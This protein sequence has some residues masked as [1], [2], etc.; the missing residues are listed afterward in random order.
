MKPHRGRPARSLILAMT[1]VGLIAMVACDAQSTGDAR[2]STVSNTDNRDR[3]TDASSG[4][5]VTKRAEPSTEKTKLVLARSKIKHVVFLIKENRT[6]DHMFGRLRRANGAV[7]GEICNG[8]TVRLRRAEDHVPDILHSFSAGIVAINGGEMNCFDRLSGGTE[9]EGYVQYHKADIPNYWSYAKQFSLADRFFSSVYGPTT[10]EHL[11]TMAGQSDR[12]VDVERVYQSGVGKQGEFCK[13]RQELM[14]SFRK[15]SQAEE[16]NAYRLEE[17]SDVSGLAERFWTERWPCTDMRVLQDLLEEQGVS[18]RYYRGGGIHQKAAIKMIRHIRLGPMWRKVVSNK[19]FDADVRRGRL[20]SVSWLLPPPGFTDHPSNPS[21]C[22]GENWTVNR[23]NLLMNSR[24]WR[25]TAVILTWDD[26]GGFYDHVPPPHVDL[27]GM[28]PR[29]PAIV[30][31]PWA[32]S[33]YVDHHTY[34]FSS[35]LKTIEEL[36]GLGS[37]GE[38]DKRADAMWQSFDFDQEPLPPLTLPERDCR[39]VMKASG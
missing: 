30:L 25:S 9:L 37:L 34:D 35:V 17:I 2:K 28:G 18:W 11:W 27:Y 38:R 36:H 14:W 29:V 3:T 12:F 26:F 6:F 19:Q 24:Y 23:L 16:H 7:T 33:G 5:S 10:V 32:R 13:D 31:S 8:T 21:I 39:S 15:L 1:L 20:P 22:Q 4:S